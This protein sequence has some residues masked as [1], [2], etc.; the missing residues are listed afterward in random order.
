MQK[1]MYTKIENYMLSCMNDGAHDSQHIY[2]VLYYSLDI[3][4]EYAVDKDVL[5]ASALLHDIGRGAQFENPDCD[6]TLQGHF[7]RNN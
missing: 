2:R 7:L 5:I 4:N 6:H 1:K 3:S